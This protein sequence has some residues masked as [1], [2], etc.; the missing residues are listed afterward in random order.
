MLEPHYKLYGAK[1]NLMLSIVHDFWDKT[2][3]YEPSQIDFNSEKVT[4]SLCKNE[5]L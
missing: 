4:P 5:M 1:V 3:L 2:E